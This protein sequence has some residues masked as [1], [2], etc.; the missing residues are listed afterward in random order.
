ML[1]AAP[2]ALAAALVVA[3]VA[4]PA[5]SAES[6]SGEVDFTGKPPTP[7]KLHREADPVCARQEGFDESVLVKDGKLANVW[8]H[9]VAGAPDSRAP[10]NAPAVTVDQKE[11]SYHPRVQAALIGQTLIATNSDATLHNVHGYQ[12]TTTIFNLAQVN[13]QAK[14]INQPLE[15]EG[16]TKLKCD[17]HTWMRGYIGVNKNPYQAV[18]GESGSFKIDLP[19]GSYTVEAWHEKLGVKSA[20]ITV[21][22]GKPA[23]LVFAYDGSEKG[24]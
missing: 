9:V 19:P 10:A 2:A 4:A 6:L 21:E 3:L 7:V 15:K 24:S 1:R 5:A 20:Q 12:G 23:K 14:P 16:I 13:A 18:T 17:V 11:C 8:V 22:A